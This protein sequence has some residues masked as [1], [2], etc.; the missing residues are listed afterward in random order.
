MVWNHQPLKNGISRNQ[1]GE[2]T[3]NYGDIYGDLTHK[4]KEP[5]LWYLRVSGNGVLYTLCIPIPQKD[6]FNHPSELGIGPPNGSLNR[7]EILNIQE[8][9]VPLQAFVGPSKS[10]MLPVPS[11]APVWGKTAGRAP[12]SVADCGKR[13][14]NTLDQPKNGDMFI[15]FHAWTTIT[16]QF[17]GKIIRTA[18]RVTP[19]KTLQASVSLA[20]SPSSPTS[21]GSRDFLLLSSNIM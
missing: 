11:T 2:I 21:S 13:T 18:S 16:I 5:I 12:A 17:L 10:Q 19:W 1:N 6:N 4:I 9:Q 20:P 7:G 3:H 15:V 14:W 8:T